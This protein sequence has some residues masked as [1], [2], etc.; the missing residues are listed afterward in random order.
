MELSF[1]LNNRDFA[2]G[3]IGAEMHL[4]CNLF[5]QVNNAGAAMG[6]P[7]YTAEGVGGSA[8]VCNFQTPILD[9]SASFELFYKVE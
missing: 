6:K 7:W 5:L 2:I 4:T 3:T 1:G 8:Q 9:T